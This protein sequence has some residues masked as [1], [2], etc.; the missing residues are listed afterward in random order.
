MKSK[1]IAVIV[2]VVV[3]IAI[4]FTLA[5]NKK[6]IDK[7][8]TPI[9][10][11]HFPVAV[12]VFEV[13]MRP[14]NSEV[15]LPALL[16]ENETATI[17]VA[18]MGKI[19]TLNIE[20]GSKVRKGQVIGQVDTRAMQKQKAQLELTVAKLKADY[21]R[22]KALK[23]GNAISAVNLSDSKY[24]YESNKLALEQLEQQIAD[25]N[26]VS[27][28]NGII[29]D[30][31]VVA[32]EFVGAG[33]PIATVVDVNQIKTVIFVSESDVYYLSQGQEVTVDSRLF[34]EKTLKGKIS[35]ISP[36]ADNNHRYKVEVTL[37]GKDTILKAGTYVN[38]HFQLGI[39]K[40]VLQVAKSALVNG[41][42]D[43][44]VYVTDG[45]TAHKRKIVLGREIG[46]YYEIIDG[47]KTGERVITAGKIN[48]T[49]GCN[50]KVEK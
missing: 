14:S 1:L 29:T 23:E 31:K 27:P 4:A 10:R 35:Y 42:L 17:S 28:L 47:L 2:L 15:S 50:V 38:V 11:S 12:S 18:S 7:Q 6:E 22:N 45:K 37:S 24:N 25:A 9:D 46:D 40:E 41:I 19:M 3:A 32:G 30:K 21:E 26:I 13:A 44:Y 16:K 33:T 39:D 8:N 48:V 36:N 5:S 43:P 49:E 34:P 20:L